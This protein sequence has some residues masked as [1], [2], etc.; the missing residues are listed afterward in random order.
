MSEIIKCSKCGR[1]WETLEEVIKNSG[2]YHALLRRVV[3]RLW[4]WTHWA[5]PGWVWLLENG[6]WEVGCWA[7]LKEAE[8]RGYIT[9]DKM[10]A[11]TRD[12]GL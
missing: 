10:F 4:C 12:W 3:F 5:W 7:G 2:K 6:A 11:I 9:K 8:E 1:P